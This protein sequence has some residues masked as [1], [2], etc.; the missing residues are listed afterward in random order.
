MGITASLLFATL[1]FLGVTHAELTPALLP[2]MPL[3][4]ESIVKPATSAGR[5]HR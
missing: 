3:L 2:G 1:H 4:P 5:Q